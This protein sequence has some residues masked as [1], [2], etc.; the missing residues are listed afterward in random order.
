MSNHP[1]RPGSTALVTGGASGIGL[2]IVEAFLSAG[3]RVLVADIRPDHL[4]RAREQLAWAGEQARF[5]SLDVTDAGQWAA[6]SELVEDEFGALHILCLNAG[7]GILGSMLDASETDW[8]WITS[9]NLHGVLLGIDTFLPHLHRHG[10]PAHI[11]ATS[12]MGGLIVAND[13]GIYS[14]AKFGVVALAEGL[15][16]DLADSNIRVSVL[17]PAAVNT[18]IFDHERMR[19]AEFQTTAGPR[20]E[21][22]I[23]EMEAF[24]KQLLALGRD[25]T[26]VGR[27]VLGGIINTEDYIFTDRNILPTLVRRRNALLAFA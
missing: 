20:N 24:A 14:A 1:V 21:V 11:V 17:C 9:V 8:N 19:P 7:V 23:D 3:L 26:E 13:G 4:A 5:F 6:V 18:N 25:P 2:G 27:M 12:S 22:L 10:Q 15:R 16:R